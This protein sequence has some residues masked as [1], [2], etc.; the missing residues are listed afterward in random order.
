MLQNINSSKLNYFNNIITYYINTLTTEQSCSP[1]HT[2]RNQKIAKGGWNLADFIIYLFKR[3]G[4]AVKEAPLAAARETFLKLVS[5]I[6][7]AGL[8]H[9][10]ASLLLLTL[11]RLC[12]EH[13]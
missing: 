6:G 8:A 13:N 3:F 12:E 5:A 4:T 1:S 11:P 10:P 2:D 9:T 7:G